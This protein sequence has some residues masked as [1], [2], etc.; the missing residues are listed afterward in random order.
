MVGLTALWLPILLSAVLVFIM[1]SLIHMVFKWHQAD[2]L[3]LPDE[4]AALDTLSKQKLPPGM[5]T[6]PRSAPVPD[7]DWQP[8]ESPAVA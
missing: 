1:S 8:Q 6:L 3:E 5:Y 7:P 2:Y 4:D